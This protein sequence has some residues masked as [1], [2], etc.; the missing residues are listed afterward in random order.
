MSDRGRGALPHSRRFSGGPALRVGPCPHPP[1][2]SSTAS[3]HGTPKSRL[4]P[5]CW[6][7]SICRSILGR[8][9][10]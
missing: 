5:L 4:K 8:V 7:H 2:A 1:P 6:A 3:S 9:E 10:G